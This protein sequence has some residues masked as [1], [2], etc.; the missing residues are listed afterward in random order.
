MSDTPANSKK[1]RPKP[2]PGRPFQ[3]GQSGNPSGRPKALA[4]VVELCR[5][6]TPDVIARL[7][8]IVRHGDE[9]AAVA[10]GKELLDRGWGKAPETVTIDDKR[11]INT[12]ELE[13]R[14]RRILRLREQ[15]ATQPDTATETKT[16]Q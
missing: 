11:Q 12:Q 3:P 13:Q 6:V 8:E 16:M 5:N 9:R 15:A 4:E 10:A 2:P 1:Q 14:V 7:H